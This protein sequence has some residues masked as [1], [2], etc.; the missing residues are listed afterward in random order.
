MEQNAGAR[1]LVHGSIIRLLLL[2]QV[3]SAIDNVCSVGVCTYGDSFEQRISA[4]PK[5]SHFCLAS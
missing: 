2:L 1:Q 5:W 4:T 3:A